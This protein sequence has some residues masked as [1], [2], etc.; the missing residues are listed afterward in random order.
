[1]GTMLITIIIIGII[2]SINNWMNTTAL[3]NLV[4]SPFYEKE[5]YDDECKFG[6][7]IARKNANRGKY[8]LLLSKK[9]SSDCG[10]INRLILQYGK[11]DREKIRWAIVNFCYIMPENAD[12]VI[13][14][15]F[16]IEKE[17]QQIKAEYE[18]KYGK[19]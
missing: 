16:E 6:R 5:F 12:K 15:Y 18:E 11:F 4:I 8:G 19:E 9:E 13:E 1:M 7:D 17:S 14:R 10:F 2:T 3:D